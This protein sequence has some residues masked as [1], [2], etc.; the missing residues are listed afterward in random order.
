VGAGAG[1]QSS[2]SGTS[3]LLVEQSKSPHSQSSKF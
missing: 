1:V 2:S 3:K